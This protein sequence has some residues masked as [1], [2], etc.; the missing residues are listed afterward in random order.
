MRGFVAHSG[1]MDLTAS[2]DRLA[3]VLEGRR[4]Q[5]LFQPIVDLEHG[6]TVGYEALARS[7]VET[8]RSPD[9]MFGAARS[10]GRVVELD[11]L[12]RE[13]AV[14]GARRAGVRYPLSLFVNAEPETLMADGGDAAR[15]R[16]FGDLRCYAE[17]TERALAAHPADLLRGVD[18]VRDEDWG[19]A[20][21]DVGADPRSLALLPVIRPDVVKL[22]LS[23]IQTR[24]GGPADLTVSRVLHPALRFAADSGAVVIAEGIETEQHLDLARAVGAHYGQGY[25]LGRPALLP[26]VLVGPAHAVPLMRHQWDRNVLT[27]PFAVVAGA[28]G[29]RSVDRSAV[30]EVA[31]QVLAQAARFD[32]EAMVAICV[33]DPDLLTDD[34][35]T[36]LGSFTGAPVLVGVGSQPA[37]TRLPAGFR[38]HVIAADDPAAEDFDIA[39]VGAYYRATL[40]ARRALGG[41]NAPADGK[42]TMA[43]SFN[44]DLVAA[45]AHSLLSRLV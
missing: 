35:L 21:D 24:A 9:A 42:L 33:N 18:Q 8:L 28:S 5:P 22:D 14:A 43:L 27:G 19:I 12:C 10:A 31:R 29:S 39:V 4:L 37:L 2:V 26:E 3:E 17:I 1:W 45:A 23:L 36:L 16:R 30:L 44:D 7:D 13:E 41:D 6:V 20:L 40:V 25:H 11:W 34:L 38:T 32:T 15:W